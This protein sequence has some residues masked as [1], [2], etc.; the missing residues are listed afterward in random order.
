MIKKTITIT[1]ITFLAIVLGLGVFTPAVAGGNGVCEPEDDPQ[2]DADGD[3][4]CD[5]SDICEGDDASGNTDSDGICDDIDNCPN[6][7]NEDQS[8]ID[9]DEFGDVCDPDIDGDGEPNA[10]DCAPEDETIFPDATELPGDNVDS[11]C[12]GLDYPTMVESEEGFFWKEIE[13]ACV[14][15]LD[16]SSGANQSCNLWITIHNALEGTLIDTV[17]AHL[18]V[19]S[20][21]EDTADC[22]DGVFANAH[23]KS[24][25]S[26]SR[27][28][29]ATHVTCDIEPEDIDTKIHIETDTRGSPSNSRSNNPN[30]VFKW[31]PT[32]CGEFEVNG[33]LIY[34]EELDENG[35]PIVLDSIGP[36]FVHTTPDDLDC[37]GVDND[38]D[39]CVFTPNEDQAD[40]DL[41]GVGDA[42]DICPLDNPDDTDNDGICESEDICPGGDDNVDTDVDGVPDFCDACQG[43]DDNVDADGDGLAC[44]EDENDTDPCVPSEENLACEGD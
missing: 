10:T 7:D 6:D 14:D 15:G 2:F 33:G 27:V 29:S 18:D 11:N 36:M 1:S 26:S 31:S 22:D 19:D 38:I 40:F 13:E 34:F 9:N 35:D 3:G 5:A 43:V 42:C 30:H 16:I 8:N 12:D 4:V 25:N 32:S 44:F 41:D 23:G 21:T 39:N 17:P 37:D 24:K 28:T 20:V